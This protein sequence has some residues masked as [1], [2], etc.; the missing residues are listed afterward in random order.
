VRNKLLLSAFVLLLVTACH[1][2]SDAASGRENLSKKTVKPV[3]QEQP[4]G[5]E[6]GE[7]WQYDM[8]TLL[9]AGSHI[10]IA[11]RDSKPT[12]QMASGNTA[13]RTREEALRKAWSLYAELSA[14]PERFA[15]VAKRE[16]DD[17]AT[18]WAGGSLGVFY[19]SQIP[20]QIVDAFGYVPEGQVSRP[21][22]TAQGYHLLRRVEPPPEAEVAIAH[23]VIKHD[24]AQGWR[25]LDRPIPSRT[26]VQA[27][28]IATRIALE[29]RQHP[30]QF[31]SLARQ[32]SDGEDAL[33]G[34]DMGSWSTYEDAS[35]DFLLLSIT[36]QLPIG[37][38]SEVVETGTGA[39]V[40][41]RGPKVVKQPVAASTITIGYKG[42]Q[43]SAY[44]TEEKLSKQEA[45]KLATKF[46][47]ELK[48]QPNRFDKIRSTYCNRP[49]CDMV[50]SWYVGRGMA[51]LE[52]ELAKLKTNAISTAPV[53]S[54][55]GYVILR[56]EDPRKNP[57]PVPPTPRFSFIPFFGTQ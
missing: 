33:R 43:L 19:A 24:Q 55:V 42:S 9:I 38:V 22:E 50:L 48:T 53:D 10:L 37:G 47:E 35:Q 8:N 34:G 5:Y 51:T 4:V 21:V 13:S 44:N 26:R 20:E 56:K 3:Q 54:P 1:S 11:H 30:E 31:E 2:T 46:A 27:R 36:S 25:R 39:H 41:L 14:H 12:E 29:A 57:V 18:A 7:W 45:Q 32:Y 28:E 23:I 15:S 17:L 16:S 49:S 6:R 40:L 52:Q